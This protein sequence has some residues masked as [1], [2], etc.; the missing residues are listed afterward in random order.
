MEKKSNTSNN[1]SYQNLT[2]EQRSVLRSL[3]TSRMILPIVI[4]LGVVAFLLWRQFDP[5]QLEQIAWT[6]RTWAWIGLSVVLLVLR[7]LAFALRMYILS[8]GHFS[9]RKCIE[10]IFIFEFS[11]SVTPTTVGGSAVSLFVMTQEKLSAA[12]TTT[13]VIYK[14]VLD[15]LFFIGTFPILFSVVGL[16]MLRPNINSFWDS[17]WRTNTFYFSYVGMM[18]YG[19]FFFYGLFIN[20]TLIKKFLLFFTKPKIMRRFRAKTEKLGDDIILASREMKSL[21]WKQHFFAFIATW[22]AWTCKFLLISALIIGIAA[23]A[24]DFWREVQLYAR[25]QS[26]FIIMAF[27]PSPGGA[28][29]AEAV[30][31]PFLEDFIPPKSVALIIAFIWRLLSYYAYLAAGAIIVPNWVRNVFLKNIAQNNLNT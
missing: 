13:I 7:H 30:F 26:M 28:G 2:A 17:D 11:L 15:S 6:G 22:T 27:S 3:S 23:P 21:A 20:P 12:R 24:M 14:I 31:H 25:L 4:G 16:T 18:I 19:L 8:Q 10:L 9:F 5:K 29:F 1:S